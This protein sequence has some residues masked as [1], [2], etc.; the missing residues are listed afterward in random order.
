[1]S[2]NDAACIRALLAGNE[3]DG[4]Q[5]TKREIAEL[6]SRLAEV[7]L[8]ERARVFSEWIPCADGYGEELMAEMVVGVQRGNSAATSSRSRR[9]WRLDSLLEHRFPRVPVL[10]GEPDN[11]L[12]VAKEGHLVVGQSGVG[13]TYFVFDM[14]LTL[15]AGGSFLGYR[16]ARPLNSLIL[17]AELPIEFVQHRFNRM[18]MNQRHCSDTAG[19]EPIS[20]VNIMELPE[21][22]DLKNPRFIEELARSVE[23]VSADVVILDPFLPFFGGD[24]NVN[25]DVRLVLDELK[26]KIAARYDCAMFV[27]DHLPKSDSGR[28]PKVRGAGS[29]IDWASMVI[30]LSKDGSR[31]SRGGHYL[32]AEVTKVRNA[33]QP[34][35]AFHLRFDPRTMR[36]SVNAPVKK[37][38]GALQKA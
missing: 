1:M 11:A 32:K 35:E 37:I 3:P 13:K 18:V 12:V 26:N 4:S 38:P 25:H 30:N 21:H 20:R 15:A 31:G 33:P 22:A 17:Q 36:L 2:S 7:P 14:A 24:E 9:I 28:G 8:E 34:S 10:V 6:A 29:K 19:R 16:I 23:G 27:V 5:P